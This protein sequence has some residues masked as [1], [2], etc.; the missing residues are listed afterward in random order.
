MNRTWKTHG[1]EVALTALLVAMAGPV[2]AGGQKDPPYT[3]YTSFAEMMTAQNARY[4]NLVRVS[5]PGTSDN[6]NYTGFFFYQCEQFDP[7]NRYILGMRIHCQNRDVRPTDRAEIGFIDL[8]DGHKW[9]Q[10]G[11]TTAWNWQQG[12]R[13]QWRPGSD[14]ILWNDRSDD[15]TRY[16]CRV[17]NFKT[18]ARRTL[19]RPIYIPSPDGATAL[20]HDF[21]R[22]KHGGTPYVGIEDRYV[23]QYAPKET[24]IWRMD[25]NTGDATLIVS[26]E[27]MAHIAYPQGQP[28]SGCFYIFREGWNPS[29]SRFIAFLKDPDNKFD[30]AF[31]MTPDGTDIRYF[32]NLPSHH[33]WRDDQ[34]ILDGRGY[35]LYEDDGTGEA[36]GRL[37]ES[38][39]NG[40]VSYIPG[41]P[42]SSVEDRNGGEWIVSDTYAIKGWQYLFL[43]H[44]PTKRFVPLA[45]LKSTAP[46]NVYRVDLHPRLS[47]DGRIVCIDATHEGL[48]RQMYVLDISHILDN[49]PGQAGNVH[50]IAGTAPPV[51]D[52]EQWTAKIHAG[53]VGKVAAGSGALA[54]EMWPK[55]RIRQTF[56]VLNAPPKPPTSRGPLDDTTLAFL[57][58][59]AAHERGTGFTTS[60]IAQEW[61]DHLTDADLQGGGFGKEFLDA[62][63]RLRHGE[64]PPIVSGSARAEWIAA[65]MRAEIWGTLAPGDPARAADYAA[66]D[67]SVFNIGNGIYAAQFVAAIASQLMTDPNLAKAIATAKPFVPADAVLTRLIDDVILWHQ[68][69][70][71]DWEKTWQSFVDAYRDRSLETQF[72]A[73]SPDWLVET[74]GW[75][76]AEVL[77]AYRGRNNVLRS[78]PFSD[79]EPACL[80]TELIVPSGGASLRL[81]VTCNDTPA[82]VDWLLR[83]RIG[84]KVS[85]AQYRDGVPYF[86]KAA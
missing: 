38:S 27:R 48:G 77:T 81:E 78:H 23:S 16:V 5:D 35:Y 63:A 1:C 28:S 57:G 30:K 9:T 85:F 47:R 49:P 4:Q 64:H 42:V 68:Q 40:H 6:P 51:L 32:Y 3:T 33:E 34:C 73:W 83:V 80:T 25:L 8:Q 36:K 13:L 29:G 22:M 61:V 7:A 26:L 71:N 53:W 15:G 37:F 2:Q 52:I 59:H 45:K 10:I 18:G 72:A 19:P 75:P 14:E 67:A 21:E 11:E 31:S 39:Y 76:E 50:V 84:D 60:H 54:T 86:R 12:A 17:Y 65:Q 56:G 58:W 69:E 20:T 82:N 41:P 46:T 79:N 70:P 43:Y 44:L 55:E 62:L 24:G 74:G 66:R